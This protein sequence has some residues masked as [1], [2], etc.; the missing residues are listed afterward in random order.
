M[1]IVWRGNDQSGG[2]WTVAQLAAMLQVLFGW[3]WEVETSKTILLIKYSPELD[4]SNSF[5]SWLFS[6]TRLWFIM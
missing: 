1:T 6:P 3:H 2:P 4:T 5:G